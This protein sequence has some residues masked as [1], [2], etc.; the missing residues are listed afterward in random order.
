MSERPL[1]AIT[2]E[3]RHFWEGTRAGELRLQKCA[4]CKHVYFPPRPFC[5]QCASS[6]V[7]V[8][9]AS[10]RATL[11]Q[12]RDSS[13]AGSGIRAAL[14]DRRGG[15]GGGPAHDDQYRRDRA[16]PG[17]AAAR[18]AARGGIPADE[19]RDLPAAV[20][21]ERPQRNRGE[22]EMKPGSIAIVGAAETTRLGVIP[23]MSQIQLHADCA[24][25]A[26][27]DAGLKPSDIDGLACAG[28]SPDQYRAL[29]RHRAELGRRHRG[30]RLLV[31]AACPTCD[32]GDQRGAVQ[33]G[34]DHARRERPIAHRRAAAEHS[35][36]VAAGSVR[37]AF[38]HLRSA[39]H[40]HHPGA[41]LSEDL[42]RNAGAAGDGGGGTARVG[43]EESARDDEGSDHGS[44]RAQ[45]EDDRLSVPALHVLPGDR[46]RR[47]ADPDLGRS[48][49]GLSAEAGIHSRHR[50]KRRRRR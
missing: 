7:S 48:R 38:R 24:L 44:R 1:P 18:H 40:V 26:M 46:R 20:S 10:G 19:R 47:R 2:P 28:E 31:H 27:R 29:P 23:D 32:S 50:R 33:D 6:D 42:R 12:L 5:P 8:F 15:A 43:G 16:D 41:A 39:D 14:F 34:A 9:R 49:E 3:T 37:S 22:G 11:L 4:A 17:S 35:A 45:F 30:R 21:A 36:G 25:N 13:S